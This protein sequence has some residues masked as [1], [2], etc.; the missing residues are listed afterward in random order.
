MSIEFRAIEPGEFDSLR[1]SLGLAFGVEPHPDDGRLRTCLPLSRTRCGFEDGLMVSTSGAHELEMTVPGGVVRCAGTTIVSVAP[2]HRRQGLLSRMMRAHLDDVREHEEPIAALWAT[3]SAIY[4]RYG[5][6]CSAVCDEVTID[7][8]HVE[9]HRLAP[10]PS[11]VRFVDADDA[12][13]LLPPFYET[14]RR[15]IPG[16]I[17]RGDDWWEHY[18]F[19]DPD[20]ERKGRTAYRYVVVDG[21]DGIAGFAQYRSKLEFAEGHGAGKVEVREL[22][23]TTPESW[24]GLWSFVLN[25]DLIAEITADLRPPWDPVFDL[26]AGT[27]RAAATRSDSLWVRIMDVPAALTARAYPAE[28]DVV[29]QVDDPLGDVSGV[30]RLSGNGDDVSCRRVAAE[31]DVAI[32]LE[33]LSACYMGRAR[34]RQ[35]ARAGRLSGDRETLTRLDLAFGWDTEPW[36]PEIF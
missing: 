24:A 16:Y 27:R 3:D 8:G 7:R 4:G 21:E 18:R 22:V 9:L 36:C 13:T 17:G 30:Y 10:S 25:L 29:L 2:T 33:D 31:A 28:V 26:L 14:I 32:D 23:G 15:T 6:G 5:F 20:H 19:Y 35:L 34:F 11:T 12:T 1:R